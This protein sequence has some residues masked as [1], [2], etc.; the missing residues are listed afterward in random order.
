MAS[1]LI[2]HGIFWLSSLDA[3]LLSQGHTG[4]WGCR[5][6]HSLCPQDIPRLGGLEHFNQGETGRWKEV[7][8]LQLHEGRAPEQAGKILGE[9]VC[10]CVCVCVC[11]CVSCLVVSD[12]LQPHRL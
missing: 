5:V 4:L 1:F 2:Y 9:V 7:W 10:V 11:M 3:P 12:S 6:E 8:G